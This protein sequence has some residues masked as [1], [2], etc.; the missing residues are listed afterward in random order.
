MDYCTQE[1][2]QRKRIISSQPVD[3]FQMVATEYLLS[4]KS[5]VENKNFS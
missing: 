1:D 5:H 4:E 2:M 3:R